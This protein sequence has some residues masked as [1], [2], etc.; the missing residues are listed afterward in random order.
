MAGNAPMHARARRFSAETITV[1]AVILVGFGR[2]V[3]HDWVNFDDP[4]HVTENPAFFPVSWRGLADFWAHPYGQLYVP[5]SYMLFAA[6]CVA[7]RSLHGDT[8]TATPRPGLFHAVSLALHVVAAVL[9]LRILRRFTTLPWAA[10]A[11]CLVFA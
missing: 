9:V 11:G 10:V 3:A 2:I 5:V 4:L 8:P 7:S 1:V 6:E